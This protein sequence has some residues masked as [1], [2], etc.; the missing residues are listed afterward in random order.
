MVERGKQQ[1]VECPPCCITQAVLAGGSDKQFGDS[2]HRGGSVPFL[3]LPKDEDIGTTRAKVL[4]SG[5]RAWRS[6]LRH[7]VSA[8]IDDGG[9]Q[10]GGTT[11]AEEHFRISSVLD[12]WQ[13]AP[14]GPTHLVAGGVVDMVP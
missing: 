8:R 7:L 13:H 6:A 4:R 12:G 3:L 5:H 14:K 2:Q 9:P 11:Q 1:K 10:D